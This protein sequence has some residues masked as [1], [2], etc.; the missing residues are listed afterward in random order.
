MISL[1]STVTV[2]LTTNHLKPYQYGALVERSISDYVPCDEALQLHSFAF[3]LHDR[4]G[5]VAVRNSEFFDVQMLSIDPSKR[6]EAR[7][8]FEVPMLAGGEYSFS[9]GC[10]SG[11]DGKV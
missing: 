11:D 4:N 9:L 1:K 3:T 10:S 8:C 5:L 2:F 7:F 6:Y